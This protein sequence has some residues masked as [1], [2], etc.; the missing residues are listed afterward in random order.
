MPFC[1]IAVMLLLTRPATPQERPEQESPQNA[2]YVERNQ[3][4]FNF[5][6]GGKLQIDAGVP[7]N[8]KVIGWQRA[9]VLIEYETVVYSME[10]QQARALV[11]QYPV[12]VR[13]NRISGTIRTSGPPQA[14]SSMEIN[15]TL[16]VPME[17]TDVYVRVSKGDLAVDALTGWIEATLLDGSIETRSLNGYFSGTTQ[18]GNIDVQMAGK[19]WSGLGFTGVTRRG[20][21]TLAMPADFSAALQLETRDGNFS[22]DYPEQLVEGESVPLKAVTRKNARTLTATV[23]DG[24]SPVKLMTFAGN[25]QVTTK[26]TP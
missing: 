25:I 19:H 2:P 5:Y 10:Q 9:T 21:V 8:V 24:G 13:Y 12:Q 4:Q 15:L 22:I 11:S 7:G 23:G 6:P 1:L 14:A 20:S 18:Q 17:K 3:R 26:P 16:H